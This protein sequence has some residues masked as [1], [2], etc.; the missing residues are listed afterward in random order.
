MLP[1]GI[2][3]IWFCNAL[4]IV[5]LILIGTHISEEVAVKGF[6]SQAGWIGFT[7]VTLVVVYVALR[8]PQLAK[9]DRSAVAGN[10]KSAEFRETAY[11]MPMLVLIAVAM[12]VAACSSGF[13]ALY[14]IKVLLGLLTLG[15]FLPTYRKLQWSWSWIAAANGAIVFVIWLLMEPSTNISGSTL[16][17]SLA[18]LPP[19]WRTVWIVFRVFGAVAVV[20]LAEELAFRGYLLRRITSA[21]FDTVDYRHTTWLAVAVSSILFGVLHGRWLAA[22]VAGV[23]YAVA[24]RRRGRLCD[25]VLAHTITNWLIAIYV[26]LTHSW[27]LWS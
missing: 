20:P 19:F 7:F 8:T 11:L 5:T 24:T 16:S 22:T 25:A 18:E 3:A 12:I 10:V 15:F 13:E 6:H 14:P 2:V 17:E 27:Q 1:V 9:V 23:F 21:N 4:R 26:L